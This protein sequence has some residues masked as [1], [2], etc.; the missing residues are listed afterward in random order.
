MPAQSEEKVKC[1]TA[2]QERSSNLGQLKS[3]ILKT[4]TV[5]WIGRNVTVL[6]LN[7]RSLVEEK[8]SLLDCAAVFVTALHAF[9]IICCNKY[10]KSNQTCLFMLVPKGNYRINT[11]FLLEKEAA[12]LCFLKA[13]R[14]FHVGKAYLQ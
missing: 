4:W 9:T 14:S 12:G 2:D 13:D 10:K 1:Q 3:I 7:Q 8:K 6:S 5:K 11:L